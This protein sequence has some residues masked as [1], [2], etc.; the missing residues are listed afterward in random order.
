MS[1][2]TTALLGRCTAQLHIDSPL[3]PMLLARTE[4]GLAGAWFDLQKHHPDPLGAPERDDPLLMRTAAQLHDYF[5]G[6]TPAFD[7]PLDLIGT[8][9]QRAVWAELLRI[10]RGITCSYG[11][12]A[13]RVGRPAAFRAV[14]AAVGRN[15]ISVIVPC[16][17]VIGSS[18][19]MTGYASGLQRKTALLG[20]EGG[21]ARQASQG[22]RSAPVQMELH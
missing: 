14:G 19:G 16:H 8:D 17:R 1:H 21:T 2:A 13:R 9:F 18:G 7:L 4:Q 20:L 11:D 10:G 12:I 22:E 5:D 6:G 15:P 3:G